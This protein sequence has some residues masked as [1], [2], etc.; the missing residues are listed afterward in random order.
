MPKRVEDVR[1]R[2]DRVRDG[3]AVESSLPPV[4]KVGD[5]GC[6]LEAGDEGL[7][8]CAVSG[9]LVRLKGRRGRGRSIESSDVI[10]DVQV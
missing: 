5:V 9:V 1:F 4:V 6:S 3:G 2:I 10:G 8:E 7:E